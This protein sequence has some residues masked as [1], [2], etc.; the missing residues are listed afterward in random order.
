[1]ILNN[2]KFKYLTHIKALIYIFKNRPIWIRIS[3][4]F[5]NIG[6]KLWSISKINKHIFTTYLPKTI[7]LLINSFYVR[8]LDFMKIFKQKKSVTNLDSN[9]WK[10]KNV[11]VGSEMTD[12]PHDFGYSDFYKLVPKSIFFYMFFCLW[13]ICIIWKDYLCLRCWQQS[14]DRLSESMKKELPDMLKELV[15]LKETTLKQYLAMNDFNNSTC[16]L[17]KNITSIDI[18]YYQSQANNDYLWAGTNSRAI[19]QRLQMISD[20]P[21]SQTKFEQLKEL[22]YIFNNIKDI[23]HDVRLRTNNCSEV[24]NWINQVIIEN[25][26][27]SEPLLN[28]GRWLLSQPLYEPVL[29]QPPD[30]YFNRPPVFNPYHKNYIISVWEFYLPNWYIFIVFFLWL[31]IFVIIFLIYFKHSKHPRILAW[32]NFLDQKDIIPRVSAWWFM[33]YYCSFIFAVILIVTFFACWETF[34]DIMYYK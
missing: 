4:Y 33:F 28:L 13:V 23:C 12:F 31:V 14:C 21:S 19:G 18:G 6:E 10:I 7:Y 32:R 5:S 22:N 11:I 26:E 34:E 8:T 29:T 2:L 1:M 27:K 20:L 3:T 30:I 15:S 16:S 9:T 25:K 17:P 24:I